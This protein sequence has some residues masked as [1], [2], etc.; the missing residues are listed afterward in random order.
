MLLCFRHV[1]IV[2]LFQLIFCNVQSQCLTPSD[3]G[4]TLLPVIDRTYFPNPYGINYENETR[5]YVYRSALKGS[6][7]YIGGNFSS[8][9][10]NTGAGVVM[11]ITATQVSTPKKWRVNGPVFA[12][13]PDGSGG[14]YIGGAFNLVGDIA[15]TNLAHINSNGEPYNWTPQVNDAVET[16]VIYKD[17]LVIGGK[18]GTTDGQTRHGIALYDLNTGTVLPPSLFLNYLTT[19]TVIHTF[20]LV[21]SVLYV[22]A[23]YNIYND[24]GSFFAINL[25]NGQPGVMPGL[26]QMEDVFALSVSDNKRRI[27]IGGHAGTNTTSNGFCMDTYNGALLFNVSVGAQFAD[28]HVSIRSIESYG[29]N[30]Y[31]GGLFDFGSVNGHGFNQ[32]GIIVFDTASGV[33]RPFLNNCNGWVSSVKGNNGVMYIGGEFTS[34]GGQNR[35]NLAL[36][37]TA[38]LT[39]N[40]GTLSASDRTNTISFSGSSLFIGGYSHSYGCVARNGLAAFDINTGEIKPWQPALTVFQLNDMKFKGDTLYMAGH[41]STGAFA[42]LNPVTAAV[43]PG[44]SL[45]NVGYDLLFENDYF[46]VAG[47][48]GHANNQSIVK[49]GLPALN[50]IM[51]WGPNPGFLV[52]SIQK[53]G[54][55]VY[56]TGDDRNTNPVYIKGYISEITDNGTTAT[57]VRTTDLTN[58]IGP[59]QFY[60]LTGAVL[61]GNKMFITG[62]FQKIKGQP[63]ESFAAINVDDWTLSPID[64]KVPGTSA[65]GGVQFLNG[66][67][68]LY[69]SFE[70][71][72]GKEQKCFAIIDTTVGAVFPDRLHLNNDSPFGYSLDDFEGYLKLN[73]IQL[74]G[75]NLFLGGNVRNVNKKMFPSVAKLQ[76]IPAGSPPSVPQ[77]ISGPD[78]IDCP[79]TS[80]AFRIINADASTRY[81]WF[82]SGQNVLIQ[83]NGIDSIYLI[84]NALSGPGVLKAIAVNECGKSDTVYKTI[85]FRTLEPTV[86]ASNLR[87]VRKT[88]TTATIKFTPGNGA[89]RIVIVK[90]ASSLT[91]LPADGQE[92]AANN[93]FG[94]GSDIGNNSYVVYKGSGDSVNLLQLSSATIYY[95]TVAEFN[96]SD[97]GT[98]YLTTSNPVIAFTT[99]AIEPTV[100]T[101]NIVFSNKTTNSITIS[102]TPGNG[103]KRLVVIKQSV[104]NA[105]NL[106]ADGVSYNSNNVMGSGSDVGSLSFVVSDAAPVT[107]TGLNE[108][109]AYRVS[110]FEYNGSD[111]NTNYLVTNAPNVLFWTRANE[112]T[113]QA[114]NIIFSSITGSS[115]TIN[116]TPGNGFG[117][118]IVAREDNPVINT[119]VDLVGYTYNTQFGIGS[120]IGNNTYVIFLGN[121][122]NM[123]NLR[124]GHTYYIKVFEYNGSDTLSNFLLTDAPTASFSTPVTPPTTQANGLNVSSVTAITANTTCNAGNGANRLFVMRAGS[125]VVDVPV[126]G[127]D[128]NANASFGLGDNIGNNTYVI[129]KGNVVHLTDL[130]PGTTYHI[131]VFEF[132]GVGTSTMYLIAGA[133]TRSFTTNTVT[134]EPGVQATNVTISGITPYTA[135]INCSAG[136]GT[137]RLIVIRQGATI[138][139]VPLDGQSYTSNTEYAHF[140][141]EMS[142]QIFVLSNT[143]AT[144]VAVTGLYPDT[145]FSVSVFEFNGSG[146]NV[147]Y[148]TTGN[149]VVSFHS[150]VASSCPTNTWTGAV[151]SSWEHPGNWSCGIVPNSPTINVV[152]NSGTVILNSN[153]T[154][155]SITIQPGANLIVNTGFTLTI[156]P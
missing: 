79:G 106:P 114:T 59:S 126:N 135:V 13:V 129:G 117:R 119:P 85:N 3:I 18:F 28:A 40:A 14:F 42:A 122:V 23:K 148:L 27:Y 91:D 133:P 153:K 118:M 101:S 25:N 73:T 120:S 155:H 96:G 99:Y 115:A 90:A 92:Y 58:N 5:R 6:T 1:S 19:G 34:I 67:I 156:V 152:I 20:E 21:D 143:S 128:Y 44:A 149:S 113:V 37:D 66:H 131:K 22:G 141:S 32:K 81:A 52:K 142:N 125:P 69:G 48:A 36:F 9:G 55:T 111:S 7:L 84:T 62:N 121:P 137:S 116:C 146:T 144:S 134:T 112:P 60:W 33:I 4:D 100:Q 154:V 26:Y 30:V 89:R 11:D 16:M 15:C 140:S 56:A 46:Y 64:V 83:N 127:I 107:V 102:C 87:Y 38:S 24:Y 57:V 54:N 53:K 151:N 138:P 65:F 71:V 98:N 77:G 136:N 150:N 124:P 109:T 12:S 147:N 80:L 74:S 132:N 31:V 86:N 94:L 51:S 39:I 145:D 93:T 70:I 43:Y 45:A 61:A 82:Y 10:P 88:A 49:V 72:N 110:I 130:I 104:V 17:T 63:R 95:V 76:M 78:S 75:S 105:P 2:I 41:F 68:Y 139:A 8:V 123:L 97:G 47:A 108:F 103:A 50:E 29:R 35:L